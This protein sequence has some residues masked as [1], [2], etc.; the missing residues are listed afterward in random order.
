MDSHMWYVG[1]SSNT[2]EQPFL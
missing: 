1:S 2:S